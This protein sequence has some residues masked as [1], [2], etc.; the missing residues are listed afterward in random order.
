MKPHPLISALALIIPASLCCAEGKEYML[1]ME[2]PSKRGEMQ[3]IRWKITIE[4][5]QRLT[6]GQRKL[7]EE[8]SDIQAE[9]TGVIEIIEMGPKNNMKKATLTVEKFSLQEEEQAPVAPVAPGT[10]ITGSLDSKG[11]EKFEAG[12]KVIDGAAAKVLKELFPLK[13]DDEKQLDDD[14]FSNTN[15]P[16]AVGSTWSINAEAAVESMPDDVPLTVKAEDIDGKIKF[17]AVKTVDG[18]EYAQLEMTMSMKPSVVKELPP[19]F[20]TS[21]VDMRVSGSML[22]PL[23]QDETITPEDS[24]T[25]SMDLSGTIPSPEGALSL[26]VFIRVKKERASAPVE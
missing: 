14:K 19:K 17:S 8:A 18:K 13:S 15:I 9:V 2:R 7:K 23:D 11:K 10:V 5:S 25:M 4:N 6:Q 26:S 12:G 1:K 16:R 21:S 24:T 20:K 22:L 3:K